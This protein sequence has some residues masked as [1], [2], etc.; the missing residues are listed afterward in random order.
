MAGAA[1]GYTEALSGDCYSKTQG[2]SGIF[3]P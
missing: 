3:N 1:A 2:E